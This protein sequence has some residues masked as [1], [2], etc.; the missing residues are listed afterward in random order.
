MSPQGN[1]TQ[2][3]LRSGARR[4]NG[5]AGRAGAPKHDGRAVASR[6]A[7]GRAV[8]SRGAAGRVVAPTREA[9]C[10]RRGRAVG[11][12]V[13]WQVALGALLLASG[14]RLAEAQVVGNAACGPVCSTEG[15]VVRCNDAI[16]IGQ[17]TGINC[18]AM[19]ADGEAVCTSFSTGGSPQRPAFLRGVYA[20]LGPNGTENPFQLEVYDEY[21]APDPGPQIASTAT[22]SYALPGDP[23]T[24]RV[25]DLSPYGDAYRIETDRIRVC[26][27]KRFTGVPD[28]CLDTDGRAADNW[29]YLTASQS[30]RSLADL[31]G[32]GDFLIRVELDVPDRTPWQPGGEC[33][34]ADAGV[35]DS[36]PMPA[37]DS[38]VAADGASARDASTAPPADAGTRAADSGVVTPDDDGCRCVQA[39][40][41]AVGGAWLVLGVAALFLGRR[42][43]HQ[44]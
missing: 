16:I 35:P 33:D 27:R 20:L 30:W 15:R 2:A 41:G 31:G 9:R 34:M 1:V 6:G 29:V 36:G 38:G 17:L 10:V 8:V 12:G 7:V 43:E 32:N 22:E 18:G 24:M 3:G 14:P 42:R 11:R 37:P 19:A 40:R 23:S 21:G 25:L 13:G 4:P 39:P 5:E 26:F 44:S 28:V